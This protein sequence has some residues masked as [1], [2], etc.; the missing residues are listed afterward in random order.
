MT[1][2]GKP[3]GVSRVSLSAGANQFRA[4]A[5]VSATGA[6]ELAG[7]IAASGLGEAHFD[8]A[9]TLRRPRAL[10]VS[11]DPADAE[12]HLLRTLE[13]NQF[14]VE[15]AP[16]GPP[17]KLD[18]YQLVIFNNWDMQSVPLPR[19]TALEAFVKQGG[20]LLWI[21]G[22][23]NVYVDA[24]R[25][26]RAGAHAARQTR[27]AAHARRHRRRAHHRQVLFHGRQEDRSGAPGGR[28]RGGES[29]AH[30]PGGRADFRQLVPVVRAAAPRRRSHFHQAAD[31]R[32]HARWRHADRSRADRSL[33]Q[34]PARRRPSTST[35]CCSRTAFPKKATA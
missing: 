12:A 9:L 34:D 2:E 25:G 22:D 20:G 27:A 21:G 7:R 17:E 15:R 10:L 19:K 16:A 31:L 6:I 1:A 35:S 23:R 11:N 24:K 33:S 28:R 14:D 29:A 13:A 26:G 8:S 3:L 4:H 32:H 30:R 18:D 5:S